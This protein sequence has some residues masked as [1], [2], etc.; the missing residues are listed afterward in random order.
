VFFCRTP[1]NG[2]EG[3]RYILQRYFEDQAIFLLMDTIRLETYPDPLC[4]DNVN[5]RY[6]IF[7]ND[8]NFIDMV[9]EVELPYAEKEGHPELAGDYIGFMPVNLDVSFNSFVKDGKMPVL[10]CGGC[11]D[12]GCWSV[13]VKIT[14]I[15]DTITW[16]NFFNPHRLDDPPEHWDYS[17]LGPFTFDK[18]Q[19]ISEFKREF[20]KIPGKWGKEPRRE[21][22]Y[23]NP[24]NYRW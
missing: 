9:R 14:T 5:L 11:G 6:H 24:E 13:V 15:G 23:N 16:S 22:W 19:Y 17:A 8:R 7:I 21:E 2:P 3:W 1:R 4:N 18:E 10:H 12:D 20:D